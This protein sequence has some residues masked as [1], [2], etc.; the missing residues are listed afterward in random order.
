M[1]KHLFSILLIIISTTIF[2]VF[3]SFS[4]NNELLH[5]ISLIILIY[6]YVPIL[7]F[8]ISYIYKTDRNTYW[9]EVK[10]NIHQFII[11][12]ILFS[13]LTI[14]LNRMYVVQDYDGYQEEALILVLHGSLI[15]VHT[16]IFIFLFI[17]TFFK[18]NKI[19]ASNNRSVFFNTI[20]IVSIIFI[21]LSL[22]CIN[23]CSDDPL[24][25]VISFVSVLSCI[26]ISVVDLIISIIKK[27]FSYSLLVYTVVLVFSALTLNYLHE[28]F[29][30]DG[31]CNILLGP[32]DSAMTLTFLLISIYSHMAKT[33][34][35]A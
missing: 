22:I 27:H 2:T 7:T 1:K 18:K 21:A 35:K 15:L 30:N 20:F 12:T 26:F 16:L 4:K 13:A 3:S 34:T 24:L 31:Q 17:K 25:F 19:T 9:L 28:I 5:R 8:S 14:I 10:K 23:D 32:N 6:A 33:L 29:D 11:L